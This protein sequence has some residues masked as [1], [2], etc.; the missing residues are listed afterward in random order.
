MFK[1]DLLMHFKFH[2]VFVYIYAKALKMFGLV[3]GRRVQR[4]GTACQR[5]PYNRVILWLWFT[6]IPFF[7][8]YTFSFRN[9]VYFVENVFNIIFVQ[10]LKINV[11]VIFNFCIFL[12]LKLVLVTTVILKIIFDFRNSEYL[13]T[14]YY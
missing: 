4:G 14:L 6:S 13:Y 11:Y 3:S 5:R 7:V 12:D 9:I 8:Q 1:L 2:E 10:I